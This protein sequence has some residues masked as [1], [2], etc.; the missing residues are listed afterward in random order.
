MPTLDLRPG[1]VESLQRVFARFPVVRRVLVFGSRA[2]GG[3]RR[4]SDIDLAVEAPGATATEWS[5]LVEALDQT[6][7]PYE[8]D[9][10]RLD[11]L[12]QGALRARIER[13]GLPLPLSANPS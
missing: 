6:S 8:M 13:D 11:T 9:V 3:A 7:V 12:Q 2:T 1:D 5:D 10:V 4:A